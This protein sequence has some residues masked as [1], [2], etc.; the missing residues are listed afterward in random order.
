MGVIKIV[1]KFLENLK[2]GIVLK[3]PNLKNSEL[4]YLES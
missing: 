3:R 1:G 4:A 2:A